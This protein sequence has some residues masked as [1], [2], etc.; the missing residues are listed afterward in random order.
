MLV[1]LP[2]MG[3]LESRWVFK[4]FKTEYGE[5]EGKEAAYVPCTFKN[6]YLENPE[7]WVEV[8]SSSLLGKKIKRHYPW[9]EPVYND[10][11][12]FVDVNII[13]KYNGE[14]VKM[15]EEIREEKKE[16]AKERGYKSRYN[17]RP[18]GLMPF[19]KNRMEASK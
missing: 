19:L 12:Q 16:E 10:E 14:Y 11:G 18:R 1:H 17:I 4:I 15:Q 3:I 5:V 7:E 2:I 9:L 6:T 13:D 8:S